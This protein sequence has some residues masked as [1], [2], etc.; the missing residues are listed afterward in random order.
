MKGAIEMSETINV[1][2]NKDELELLIAA[3]DDYTNT[4][5]QSLDDAPEED[6]QEE[7]AKYQWMKGVKAHLELH[8]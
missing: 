6:Y 7:S 3:L 4:F 2:L 5:G 8:L 1:K